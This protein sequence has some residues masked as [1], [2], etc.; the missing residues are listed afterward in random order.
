MHQDLDQSK[1]PRFGRVDDRFSRTIPAPSIEASCFPREG[2]FGVLLL[3][4]SPGRDQE[5]T[6]CSNRPIRF[7][8]SL[9]PISVLAYCSGLLFSSVRWGAASHCTAEATSP[10][11]SSTDLSKRKERRNSRSDSSGARR[12]V[13]LRRARVRSGIPIISAKDGR[14]TP[15]FVVKAMSAW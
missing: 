7:S 13:A 3:G 12:P 8:T 9:A 4:D 11:K 1:R 15:E 2:A 10:S 14:L 5:K 6:P